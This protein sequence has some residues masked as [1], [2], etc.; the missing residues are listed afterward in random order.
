MRKLQAYCHEC[1]RALE[2]ITG[3]G[4]GRKEGITRLLQ[5]IAYPLSV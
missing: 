5:D 1:G 2:T 4:L 3:F